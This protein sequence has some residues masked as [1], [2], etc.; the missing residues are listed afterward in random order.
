MRTSYHGFIEPSQVVDFYLRGYAMRSDRELPLRARPATTGMASSSPLSDASPVSR[1][2]NR[3]TAIVLVASMGLGTAFAQ[4]IDEPR[5]ARAQE[6]EEIVVSATRAERALGEIPRSITV[7]TE[8]ELEAQL[9]INRDLSGILAQLVPGLATSVQGNVNATGQDQIRGRRLQLVVDGVV[10]NNNLVDFREE[11]LAVEP[12]NIERVE[13][14]RGGSAVYGFGAIGGVISI[15][16]KKPTTDET[17]NNTR[18]G[19]G[20]NT[21]NLGD[22][23]TYNVSHDFSAKPGAFDLRLFGAYERFNSKFD[24]DGDRIPT[25]RSLDENFDISWN[26]V[27]GYDIDDRQRIEVAAN[28]YKYEEHDRYQ[29]IG[30]DA[31]NNI[32]AEAVD[33]PVGV[34]DGNALA[35]LD[36]DGD[37]EVADQDPLFVETELYRGS[38]THDDLLNS[39]V[40][41]S[42]YQ[43]KRNN[44]SDLF[45]LP[46]AALGGARDIGTNDN[47]QTRTGAK[48][49][50][51]TRLR[52]GDRPLNL[53]WGFDY[54]LVEMDSPVT[55]ETIPYISPPVEQPS[56]A[57]FVQLD[58]TFNRL[59]LNAGVRHERLEPQFD[60]FI[61]IPNFIA[62]PTFQEQFVE[63]GEFAF[64]E[65]LPNA[66]FVY[67][68]NDAFSVF[69]NYSRGMSSAEILSAVRWTTAPSV[70]AAANAEP[71]LVDSYEIGARGSIGSFFYTAAAFYSD[72]DLGATFTTI[73]LP[74]GTQIREVER[75]PERVWGFEATLDGSLSTNTTVGGTLSWQDGER[76]INDDGDFTDLPGTRIAPIKLTG[77]LNHQLNGD[78]DLMFQ[79]I[80]AD[81]QDRFPGSTASNEGDVS[82][83]FL[84]DTS[85]GWS[86]GPGRLSV[87]VNNLLDDQY[88]PQP[89]EAKSNDRD[90]IAAPGRF[91]TVNYNYNW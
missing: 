90:F 69:G 60:D 74:N 17:I 73:T 71:Q 14:I 4:A 62:P 32:K 27:F 59:I 2:L 76:D 20:F 5:S 67:T 25:Q 12:G 41:F 11:F 24:G 57:Q 77:Y 53:V 80:W 28:Y 65:W 82:S 83:L 13:I 72:S 39:G 38:Y 37:G 35:L 10:L 48:L 70:N 52:E 21:S 55:M 81:S 33:W 8:Q 79:F 88:I 49:T 7:I 3:G 46:S 23:L 30:G 54:E 89:L 34:R 56:F 68:F 64:D 43:M 42:I 50:V 6:I 61:V 9:E 1:W 58:A 36:T 63:G 26:A 66:G 40:E 15:E 22:S 16:T 18:V 51:D 86:V 44:F 31:D 29:P 85:V 45:T 91:V 75:A 78:I 47:L 87:A 19:T 84:V